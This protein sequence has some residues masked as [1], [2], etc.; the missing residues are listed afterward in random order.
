MCRSSLAPPHAYTMG[1]HNPTDSCVP[2]A[3][4]Y[5]LSHAHSFYNPET[6]DVYLTYLVIMFKG[7]NSLTNFGYD[8]ERPDN[9]LEMVWTMFMIVFQLFMTAYVLGGWAVLC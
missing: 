8:T 9:P 2:T 5:R 1:T 6:A 7:G 4:I 3:Q